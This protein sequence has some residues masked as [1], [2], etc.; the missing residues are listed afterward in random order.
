MKAY[1]NSSA[2]ISAQHSTDQSFPWDCIAG[3]Q[4]KMPV[5]EP[6][7]KDFIPPMKM[8]RMNKIVRMGIAASVACLKSS[9]LA[10]PEAI[11]TTTGWGCLADTY[12]F[13]DEMIEKREETLSP[14]TF[15]QSTHN[16][17]GGQIALFFECQ[18]YNNVYVNHTISFENGLLDAL[19]LIAEGKENVLVGGIDE[20]ANTDFEL[21]KKSGFWKTEA[22][23]SSSLLKSNSPGTF[24]GE[25]AAFFLLTGNQ[26]KQCTA[27]IDAVLFSSGNDLQELMNEQTGLPL[28]NIDLVIS[29]Y[30]GDIRMKEQYE[31]FVNANFPGT[32]ISYYKHLCGEYDTASAFA[33]WLANEIIK[34]QK[35][36]EY[37]FMNKVNSEP[38]K[39]NRILIHTFSE[40]ETHACILVSKAGL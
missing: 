22:T 19:I 14:A 38:T 15:I 29:G 28:N 26:T 10:K 23:E 5:I 32:L 3:Y 35:L 16:T 37:L 36:P 31:N 11:I 13:L 34:T 1:I 2:A 18:E 25:G 8:R 39:I 24:A 20:I 27:C 21:K 12:K 4:E 30:N 17:V 9:A 40:P 6:D 7:Y 33:L